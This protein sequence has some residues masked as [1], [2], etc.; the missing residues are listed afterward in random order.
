MTRGELEFPSR[1]SS[2]ALLRRFA[3]HTALGRDSKGHQVTARIGGDLPAKMWHDFVERA[4]RV[5]SAP[6]AAEGTSGPPA[7]STSP[8][9]ALADSPAILRG[10]PRVA[11]TATLVFW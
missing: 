5:I 6:V 9:P 11:D 2:P 4:E 8:A 10:V 7:Q 3:S 1:V